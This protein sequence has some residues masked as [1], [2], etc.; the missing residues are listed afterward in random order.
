MYDSLPKA[1]DLYWSSS[2]RWLTKI[3]IK[4]NCVT[5]VQLQCSAVGG[6]N[7]VKWYPI[8]IWRI[9]IEKV[10]LCA[11]RKKKIPKETHEC[12]GC[13]YPLWCM[14][15]VHSGNRETNKVTRMKGLTD[16]SKECGDTNILNYSLY[17]HL[18]LIAVRIKQTPTKKWLWTYTVMR[19]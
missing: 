3:I 4:A 9:E 13:P 16:T 15:F 19:S 17:Q 14:V 12:S 5:D 2:G 8:F 11:Q 1:F 10:L 7:I 6:I 18:I